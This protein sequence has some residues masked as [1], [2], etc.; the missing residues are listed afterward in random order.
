MASAY[1]TKPKP[2]YVIM[3]FSL[4][5]VLKKNTGRLEYDTDLFYGRGEAKVGQRRHHQVECGLVIARRQQGDE[6]SC[7][8]K[9]SGP[10]MDEVS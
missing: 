8:E 6:F 2:F 10:C 5:F 3:A 7:F 4:L 1:W 9:T